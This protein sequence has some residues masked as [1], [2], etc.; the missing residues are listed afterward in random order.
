VDDP[1]P[2]GDMN[3]A[4]DM[5]GLLTQ[6][7]AQY[8]GYTAGTSIPAD[9]TANVSA[10]ETM[11]GL[12]VSGVAMTG[13][14]G[15]A[16]GVAELDSEGFVP[17]TELPVSTTSLFIVGSSVPSTAV[18]LNGDAYWNVDSGNVYEKAAGSWTEVGSLPLDVPLS[19]LYACT[20]TQY[21]PSTQVTFSS[22]F[23]TFKAVS[24]ANVNTGSFTAPASGA[25]VVTSSFVAEVSSVAFVVGF[26]LCQHGTTTPMIGNSVI[27]KLAVAAQA[28]PVTTTFLVNSLTSGS[29]Y[30][31]DLMYATAGGSVSVLAFANTSTAPTLG[32]LTTGAPV[33]MTVQGV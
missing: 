23:A 7:L 4:S 16:G 14:L 6:A 11:V 29:A 27:T 17:T 2:P 24:S 10:V 12:G 33:T 8:S 28:Q 19:G 32:T 25:V 22:T 3:Q 20:P 15:E 9:N 13:T 26:G 31:F 30:T 5:L 21:A 18:G 1:N